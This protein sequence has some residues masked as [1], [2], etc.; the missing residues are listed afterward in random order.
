MQQKLESYLKKLR[1]L[2]CSPHILDVEDDVVQPVKALTQR[3]KT[4]QGKVTK[5]AES[6]VDEGDVLAEGELLNPNDPDAKKQVRTL[7]QA[8][9]RLAR[10]A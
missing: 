3:V 6:G 10:K 5:V 1:D 7:S 4:L 9:A 2:S 8:L